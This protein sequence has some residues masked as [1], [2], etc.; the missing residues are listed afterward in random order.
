MSG[1]TVSWRNLKIKLWKWASWHL[2]LL[3]P[4]PSLVSCTKE[5]VRYCLKPYEASGTGLTAL[6][7]R[8]PRD[9]ETGSLKYWASTSPRMIASRV[10]SK[11]QPIFPGGRAASLSPL[12][13][14][15]DPHPGPGPF[16]PA[17]EDTPPRGKSC[18]TVPFNSLKNKRDN[19]WASSSV[20]LEKKGHPGVVFFYFFLTFFF[21]FSKEW[22]HYFK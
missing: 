16:S 22:R 2:D 18:T 6:L 12:E 1:D 9:S 4:S 8:L 21:P 7:L 5:P 15:R 17:R 3:L 10:S 13:G 20:G 14:E 19:G 11:A